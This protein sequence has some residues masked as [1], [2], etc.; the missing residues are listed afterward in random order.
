MNLKRNKEIVAEF[1]N[2]S[3]TRDLAAK[4]GISH[5]RISQILRIYIDKTGI[6]KIA[7]KRRKETMLKKGKMTTTICSACGTEFPHYKSTK[8]VFCGNK[9]RLSIFNK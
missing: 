4:H 9:C 3:S 8:R 1:I 5:Q 6:R 2:G 7:V